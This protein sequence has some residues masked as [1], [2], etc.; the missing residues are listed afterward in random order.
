MPVDDTLAA[1]WFRR[2]AEHGQAEG[3]LMLGALY[4]FGEGVPQSNI[5]AYAQWAKPMAQ[6]TPVEVR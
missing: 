1:Y 3:Q 4:F 6:P 2:A 5:D